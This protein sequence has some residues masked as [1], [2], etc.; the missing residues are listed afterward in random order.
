MIAITINSVARD[1]IV[2]DSIRYSKKLSK[3][4][5]TLRFSILTNE[6]LPTVGQSITV[7]VDGEALFAG[8]IT[9]RTDFTEQ[10]LVT[11]HN[12]ICMDGYYELDRRL[13]V[14]SYQST[15]LGDVVTDII[16]N[17]T[18]GFTVN[19]PDTT[20]TVRSV[21]FNYEQPS[22][23]LQKLANAAGWDWD[24]DSNNVVSFYEP[25]S[26]VAPFE[27]NDD[28]GNIQ[29]R[30]LRFDRDILELANVVYIRGGEYEDEILEADAVDKYKANGTDN[31]FP[32]VYRYGNVQVTLNGTL[33]NVGVDFIDD[34]S[35]F[36]CLYNFQ[37][38]M[39]RFPDGTL[40]EDDVVVV[41]GDAK[42]PLLIEAQD[43]ESVETYGAREYIDI[44]TSI[45]SIEEA[46]LLA[47]SRL[48]Q[49]RDGSKEGEFRT[50]ETGFKVGQAVT[51][52]SALFGVNEEYKVNRV[53]A[54][55]YDHENLIYT[56]EFIKS[57]ETDFID[58]LIGLLGREKRNITIADNEVLQRLRK[59]SDSFGFSDEIVQVIK[60]TGPY[61]YGT[62]SSGTVGKY[63]F[64]TYS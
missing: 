7:T 25:L 37:E 46:E 13:V 36:D 56:I 14:K 15:T 22:Q 54:Q 33:Q 62:A 57:G 30:S 60:T 55:M 51:V 29:H 31:T 38:K 21:K 8:T 3:S 2:Q 27:V 40:Q 5:A 23:C 53:S 35:D 16:T 44:D 49:K 48:D 28:D 11:A 45:T 47:S 24:V 41:F 39:V 18:T 19:V 63:G 43:T 52:N 61:K 42:V 20:P 34:P 17:Y 4:P 50:L 9:E 1:D 64:S 59:L 12:F 58:M 6:S 26:L 10:G 32:L